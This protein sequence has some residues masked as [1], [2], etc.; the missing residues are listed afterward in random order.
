MPV[1]REAKETLKLSLPISLGSAGQ[2]FMG[3]LDSLMI[4]AFGAVPLAASAFTG[5][6]FSF[7]YVAGLGLLYP[8]AVLT[9]RTQPG[10]GEG[11]RWLRHALVLGLGVSLTACAVMLGMIPLLGHFGQPPEVLGAI[12]P[13]YTLFS[14]SIIPALLFHALKQYSEA[15]GEPWTPMVLTF[16]GV[17]LNGALNWV[18]IYGHLGMPQLGLTG[19]GISTLL[20]R[21][22]IVVALL[23][24]LSRQHRGEAGWPQSLRDWC[25]RI[26]GRRLREM[27]ALGLPCSGQLL[28]EVCAFSAATVMMG[29]L[30]TRALAA[31][32]IALSC[33]TF[34]FMFPLGLATAVSIRISAA[35]GAGDAPRLRRIGLSSVGVAWIFMTCFSIVFALGGASLAGFFV[36]DPEVTTLATQ[37]LL[38]AA[39]F[40]LFDGT[41]VICSGA[42]RGLSDVKIP[43]LITAIAYWGL[44]L[45]VSYFAGVR[46]GDPRGVWWG[47]AVGLGFAAAA[48]ALRLLRRTR[49]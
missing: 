17:V 12:H 8:V 18:L 9:A 22:A 11:P 31:H 30:G 16:C 48:L 41:Q 38:I 26:E 1:V 7:F 32:Q 47:L 3:V 14:L 39:L 13:F 36:K 27:L 19:A 46:T 23:L 10:D 29:W 21:C 49:V 45:P 25:A 2:V 40:Q 44:A 35:Y 42:L 33:C 15:R 24:Q 20:S 4:G 6:V 34:T 37:L 43:T 28:F 5:G